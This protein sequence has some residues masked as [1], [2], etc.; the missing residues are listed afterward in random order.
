MSKSDKKGWQR[1]AVEIF[2]IVFAVILALVVNEWRQNYN[3]QREVSRALELVRS[4]IIENKKGMEET[5]ANQIAYRD[6]FKAI[7]FSKSKKQ[8]KNKSFAKVYADLQQ[9]IKNGL[10]IAPM[11]STAWITA[12]ELGI[13]RDIDYSL[14]MAFSEME[15]QNRLVN[16]RFQ[17]MTDIF[18]GSEFFKQGSAEKF[19]GSAFVVLTDLISAEQ[20]LV[21]IYDKILE[22]I[23]Q[24]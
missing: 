10:Q 24:L 23:E 1:I 15:E 13:V 16:Y 17:A 9:Q 11:L 6:S 8:L 22:K 3:R 19:V 12:K 18:Y 5:I 21:K 2:S 4:E 14:A 7:L 20:E